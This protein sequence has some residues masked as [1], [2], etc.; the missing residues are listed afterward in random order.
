[1]I[2][3]DGDRRSSYS[4]LG[5]EVEGNLLASTEGATPCETRRRS[6]HKDKL[7]APEVDD[8]GVLGQDAV[9]HED[10]VARRRAAHSEVLLA[11]A[12]NHAVTVSPRLARGG[13]RAPRNRT[14]DQESSKPEPPNGAQEGTDDED[15]RAKD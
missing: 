8:A 10:D 15:R 6:R 3:G 4:K 2:E 14:T 7:A 12:R 9:T 1:V 13:K 11:K 5:A